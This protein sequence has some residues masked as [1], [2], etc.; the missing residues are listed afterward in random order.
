LLEDEKGHSRFFYGYI[1]VAA[2]FFI[3]LLAWGASRTYGVFFTPLQN[4]FGWSRATVSGAY[5][6][7]SILVGVASIFIGRLTDRFGPRVVL[8]G[9][10]VFL[11]L[12]YLMMSLVHD[13][14]Q[15]YIFY[16]LLIAIGMS[17]INVPLSSTI[18][19]WFT[20]K[21]GLIT[22]VIGAGVGLGT[23][24]FPPVFTDLILRFDWRTSY[25]IVGSV[26]LVF[27]AAG[28]WF[29]RRDPRSMGLAPYGQEKI[30]KRTTP[31]QL[32]LGYSFQEAWRTWQFG[33]CCLI[34]FC[35]GILVDTMIVHLTRHALD[36]GLEAVIA[37]GLISAVGGGSIGGRLVWGSTS[38]RLGCRKVLLFIFAMMMAAYIGLQFA[39]ATWSLYVFAVFF[40]FAYGGFPVLHSLTTAELFGLRSHGTIMGAFY[41]CAMCGAGLGPWMAGLIYDTTKSYQWAFVICILVAAIGL[42]MVFLLRPPA[43]RNLV[44]PGEPLSGKV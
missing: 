18:A 44:T 11:G 14:W 15:V 12:G 10:G 37:A 9:C 32:D 24:I 31:L 6:L 2:C 5:T 39:V 13:L 23:I 35:N 25:L 42:T 17:G 28:A 34:F 33:L 8:F 30:K 16:G 7:S 1:I 41:F 3:M 19:R 26:V 27:I 43:R 29:L 4:E 20:S 22:G 40:G 21:R 38:D 36:I